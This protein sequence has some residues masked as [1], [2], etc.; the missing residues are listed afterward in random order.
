MPECFLA[1]F[2][3]KSS[4]LSVARKVV[5]EMT[6]LQVLVSAHMTHMGALSGVRFFMFLQVTLT[7]ES[8]VA[9]GAGKFFCI[10]VRFDMSI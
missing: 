4:F 5:F 6:R 1:V 10:R 3:G 9:N 8:L 2:A 7:F